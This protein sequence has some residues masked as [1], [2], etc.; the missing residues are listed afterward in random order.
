MSSIP[1]PAED[2]WV[3]TECGRPTDDEEGLCRDCLLDQIGQGRL[4]D[5][6]TPA[7]RKGF[8]VVP[9]AL[10]DAADLSAMAKFMLITLMRYAWG[11]SDPYPGQERLSDDMGISEPSV[12]KYSA[13]LVENGYLRKIRRGRGQTIV[14]RIAWSKLESMGLRTKDSS[15]LDRKILSPKKYEVEEGPSSTTQENAA[16]SLSEQQTL[17]GPDKEAVM[18]AWLA[19]PSL[20]THHKEY[21]ERDDVAAEVARALRRHGGR[22]GVCAAIKNYGTVLGSDDFMW[23][24]SW[25]FREFLKRGIDRFVDESRPLQAY[26]RVATGVGLSAAQILAMQDPE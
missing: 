21:F 14:Y 23:S 13:E 6:D 16:R 24:H 10:L 22:E 7:S 26:A 8:T 2:T 25:P 5:F 11:R 18:L 20:I 12:R 3:C 4:L 9:N 1:P 15:V 19:E 17:M